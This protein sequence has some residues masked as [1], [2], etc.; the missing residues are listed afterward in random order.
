MPPHIPSN[1][2]IVVTSTTCS[3]CG[4]VYIKFRN[5]IEKKYP[6]LECIEINVQASPQTAAQLQVFSA[7]TALLY[8]DNKEY[9]RFTGVFSVAQA[10]EA[11]ERIYLLWDRDI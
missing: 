6:K 9:Q 11:I 8:F 2:V 3:A 1:G 7:P 10:D 5:L 4:E